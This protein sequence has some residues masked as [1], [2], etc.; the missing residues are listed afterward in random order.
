MKHYELTT[1]VI[2]E[3]LRDEKV[4]ELEM[5]AVQGN[6]FNLFSLFFNILV[7]Y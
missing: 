2:P 5:N 6:I 4:E 3:P 1:M 7:Y